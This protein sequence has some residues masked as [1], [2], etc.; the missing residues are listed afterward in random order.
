MRKMNGGKEGNIMIRKS[1][2]IVYCF[3]AYL[4]WEVLGFLAQFLLGSLF[5]TLQEMWLG[6]YIFNDIAD[7]I[8][9]IVCFLVL[10]RHLYQIQREK[11]YFLGIAL[12]PVYVSVL[13]TIYIIITGKAAYRVFSPDFAKL[14]LIL[15]ITAVMIGIC[16]EFIW[17]RVIFSKLLQA[18]QASAKGVYGAVIVS[19]VLFGLCH[20]MNMLY[21]GQSFQQTTN[22]VINAVC[23]GVFL[24]G[25]Y[26]RFGRMI[27]PIGIHFISDFSNLFMNEVLNYT[28][29]LPR[30]DSFLSVIVPVLYVV[31]GLYSVRTSE[32]YKELMEKS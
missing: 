25:L 7:L 2:A 12:L 5:P 21:G 8:I 4:L 30:I 20:Y 13:E 10:G 17:R 1:R 28:Y 27:V 11:M 23:M 31:I 3:G 6:N 19:S 18:W 32:K 9:F 16:E 26:Y 22:Q 15:I 29:D 24:A 14:F